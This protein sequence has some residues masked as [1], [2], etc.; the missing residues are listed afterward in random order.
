[1]DILRHLYLSSALR[2][3]DEPAAIIDPIDP[4]LAAD[5]VA[6]DPVVDPVADPAADPAAVADPAPSA[7]A[8]LMMPMKTFQ[9]VVGEVREEKRQERAA[10]EAAEQK[11]ADLQAIIERMQAD[12]AVPAAAPKPAAPAA[13]VPTEFQAAVKAQAA[14][15]RFVEDTVG[16]RNAGM[17]AF[18]DF[19]QSLDI[20][21]AVGATTNDD[22]VADLLAVD[23]AGAHILVDKLAKD[24]EKAA[25]LVGM[26]SRRRIAELTRM[27]DAPKTEIKPEAPKPAAI[28]KA[29]APAPRLAPLASAPEVDPTTPDGDA[30]MDDKA[31]EA[32]YKSKYMK[33]TG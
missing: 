23:K 5:P 1:M 8:P 11:A 21:A 16:V 20:L 6:A 14:H 10:R 24:P 18:P 9:K 17:S 13:P 2:A 29:P 30:K 22:F 15:D 3:P 19:A 12:P 33:R 7:P 27:A 32:W 26:D 4:V 28:S 31:W 25:S